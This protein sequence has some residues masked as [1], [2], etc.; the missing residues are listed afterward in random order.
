MF[1]SDN[2][3]RWSPVDP[4]TSDAASLNSLMFLITRVEI[5]ISSRL[6]GVK[7]FPVCNGEKGKQKGVESLRKRHT[8]ITASEAF[9]AA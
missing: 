9:N 4:E 2:V 5:K 7:S 6:D 1:L 3:I 8:A